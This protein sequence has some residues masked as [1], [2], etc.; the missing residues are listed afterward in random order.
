MKANYYIRQLRD[1]RVLMLFSYLQTLPKN[2]SFSERLMACS[3]QAII[4]LKHHHKLNWKALDSI[5]E[6]GT[7]IEDPQEQMFTHLVGSPLGS[8]IVFPGP[9]Q[10]YQYQLTRFLN[11]SRLLRIDN[12]QLNVVYFLLSL[13]QSIAQKTNAKRYSVG[14]PEQECVFIPDRTEIEAKLNCLCFSRRE[15]EDLAKKYDLSCEDI[16]EFTFKVISKFTP[17]LGSGFFPKL[18]TV[19]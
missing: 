16:E 1:E 11:L 12:K 19:L 18:K 15:L 14:V 9:F 17:I 10:F 13:S 6:N 7:Q 4:D 2:S 5:I 3:L 8:F